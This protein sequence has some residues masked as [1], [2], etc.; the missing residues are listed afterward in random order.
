MD[1]GMIATIHP[2]NGKAQCIFLKEATG[3]LSSY[4]TV[5]PARDQ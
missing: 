2:Y 5:E 4:E 3:G 1:R